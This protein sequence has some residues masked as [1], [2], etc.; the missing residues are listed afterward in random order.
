MKFV[1]KSFSYS[2]WQLSMLLLPFVL[3]SLLSCEKKTQDEQQP[4]IQKGQHTFKTLPNLAK[5]G[6]FS[7][8]ATDGSTFTLSKSGHW[9]L[10][11][12]GYSMCPDACP[13]TMSKIGQVETLLKKEK[14]EDIIEKML[15][16]FVT[17]DPERDN[18]Q[19]LADYL[20]YFPVRALGL[21][22]DKE[23]IDKVAAMYNVEYK[24][25]DI[26]S[27]AGYAVDHSTGVFLIDPQ[28]KLR[29]VFSYKDNSQKIASLLMA[30]I[31][32]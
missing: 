17:V 21:V 13:M 27:A 6:D 32:K 30:L 14:R 7:M 22:S 2:K 12:F 29:Y 11:Y 10:L 18:P 25:V 20:S 4:N 19:K 26:G 15:T 1:L 16:V 9:V 31:K 28:A 23:T 5:G 3:F 24:F 8:P